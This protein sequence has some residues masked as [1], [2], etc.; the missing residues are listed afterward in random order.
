MPT[1]DLRGLNLTI[2][3]AQPGST[4]ED[5]IKLLASWTATS[6]R[7]RAQPEPAKA[8]GTT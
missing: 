5:Q 8:P 1:D 6:N 3:T 7:T 4:S 2:Y